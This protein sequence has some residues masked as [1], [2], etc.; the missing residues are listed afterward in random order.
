[1]TMIIYT[2]P[3]SPFTVPKLDKSCISKHVANLEKKLNDLDN[4]YAK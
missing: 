3:S 2:A 4:R 1:M